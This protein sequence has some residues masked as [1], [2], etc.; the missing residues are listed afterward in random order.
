MP[1]YD[2]RCSQCGLDFDVSRRFDES[3]NSASCP[4]DGATAVRTYNSV[5]SSFVRGSGVAANRISRPVTGGGKW[6]HHGHSHGPGGAS[7]TH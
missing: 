2:F 7:H 6:S 5:P 4:L 3:S 1:R